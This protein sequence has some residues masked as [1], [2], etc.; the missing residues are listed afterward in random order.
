MVACSERSLDDF[1]SPSEKV[2]TINK[3]SYTY[4]SFKDIED[5]VCCVTDVL[6]SILVPYTMSVKSNSIHRHLL[7]RLNHQ[8][9]TLIVDVFQ[10]LPI[11]FRLDDFIYLSPITEHTST[12]GGHTLS[13]V[14]Q[15]LTPCFKTDSRL[16]IN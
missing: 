15:N 4:I 9:G 14:L 10:F 13:L 11:F 16:K 5:H 3:I 1:V 7:T 2:S 12:S 8:P 6:C